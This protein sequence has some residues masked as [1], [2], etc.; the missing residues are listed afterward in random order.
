MKKTIDEAKKNIKQ[1]Q[2]N[3]FIS[4]SLTKNECLQLHLLTIF[5]ESVIKSKVKY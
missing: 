5:L 2:K 1:I 3:Y 4:K